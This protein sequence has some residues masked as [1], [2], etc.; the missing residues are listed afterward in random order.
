MRVLFVAPNLGTGGA[1]SQWAV[2]LPAMRGD[3]IDV[4]LLT[5]DDRGRFFDELVEQGIACRCTGIRGRGDA[6]R[7]FRA[8]RNTGDCD[9]VVS[10]GVS[11]QLVA[12]VIA[13]RRRIPHVVTEHTPVGTDGALRSLRPHQQLLQ[14]FIVAQANRVIAVSD[15]Q[16]P[17]LVGIGFPRERI[18]VIPNGVPLQPEVMPDDR[19]RLRSVYGMANGE[20]AALLVAALRPEKRVGDFVRA[21]QRARQEG[22]TVRG[23]VA[24]DGPSREQL[25]GQA[26]EAVIFLGDRGDVR[27]LMMAADIVCLTSEAEA[28][29]MTLLEASSVGRAMLSTRVGGTS[30]VVSECETGHLVD[31]G[32]FAAMAAH[33]RHLAVTPATV[34]AYGKAARKLHAARY[35][36]EAMVSAYLTEFKTVVDANA[37]Y[38]GRAERALHRA[39]GAYRAATSSGP[40]YEPQPAGKRYNPSE[41]LG[42]YV[43]L[44]AKTWAAPQQLLTGKGE[45]IGQ[46]PVARAQIALGW[47]ERFLADERY[48][49]DNFLAE[50]DA[51]LKVSESSGGRLVWV[52]GFDFA[53]YGL[54]APW[55]SAMAQGQ[56]ASVL[57]RAYSVTGEVRYRDAALKALAPLTRPRRGDGLVIDALYGPVLEEYPSPRPS[58]VLNGWIF[59]LWGLRDGH[60][61]LGDD[62][63]GELFARSSSALA[64]CLRAYDLGWWS[65]YSLH[66]RDIAKPF[67]HRLHVTQLGVMADL[68]GEMRFADVA[69]R[70]ANADTPMAAT[71]AVVVKALE[72]LV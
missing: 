38:R 29:P 18:H 61:L 47:F 52:Y 71:R 31:V 2:L 72:M 7:L 30:D 1:Q 51:L 20:L 45:L 57:T 14:R 27:E 3:E 68:T 21:V 59:A 46:T 69:R 12:A 15:A 42:Y 63:S 35:T 39:R 19:E 62:P 24:G 49:L 9:V 48:A 60:V 22:A 25:Q 54:R 55:L 5:L 70:W 65:R 67:Y 41:A 50:V 10:R 8:T 33:L 66:G 11:A 28:L 53:K 56:A 34:V 32:D 17:G 43:D 37:E 64:A 6:H 23:F 36:D 26:G 40:G 16:I 58:H 4:R 13:R 44:R